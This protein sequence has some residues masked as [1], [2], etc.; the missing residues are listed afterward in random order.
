VTSG[1]LLFK[2]TS[3]N[4]F[5]IRYSKK[6]IKR[7][8]RLYVIWT[9]IYFPLVLPDILGDEKGVT[10]AALRYLRDCI[11]VGSY[12]QLWYLPALIFAVMIIS[13]LLY[14]KIQPKYIAALAACFYIVGLLAQSWFGVIAPLKEVFPQAWHFLQLLQK[15]IYTTRDGLFEGFFFVS[16]GMCFAFY[17]ISISKATA[18]IGFSVSMF[19]MFI[20]VFV[21]QHFGFIRAHDMYLFLTPATFFL[22]GYI[23]QIK[24][25]DN[26]VFKTLRLLSSLIFYLHLWVRAIVLRALRMIY[27][28]LAKSFLLFVLTLAVTII[29]SFIIIKLSEREKFKWLKKLYS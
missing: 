9:L 14:K 27:E 1:F 7:I 8:L 11:F 26:P 18:L 22:F 2:K 16:I 4:D 29:C 23:Q 3:L 10:Y 17:N 6:Y 25:P 12:T 28:P 21:L 13:V 15:V 19:A 24:L 20:E 5:D